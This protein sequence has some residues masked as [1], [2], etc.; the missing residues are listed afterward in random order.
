MITA[1]YVRIIPRLNFFRE[2]QLR[3]LAGRARLLLI[4]PDCS[5]P[6]LLPQSPSAAAPSLSLF[7]LIDFTAFEKPLRPQEEVNTDLY[8]G[9]LQQVT[10]WKSVN[11][12]RAIISFFFF[13]LMSLAASNPLASVCVLT[14]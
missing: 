3:L 14:F 8:Q 6:P 11:N 2:K 10:T 1:A 4:V 5:A 13:F 9:Q 12:N 7:F